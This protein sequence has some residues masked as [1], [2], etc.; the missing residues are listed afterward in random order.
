MRGFGSA[1][2]EKTR[3]A[4][5]VSVVQA[6]FFAR[7]GC[8]VARPRIAVELL[9]PQGPATLTQDAISEIAEACE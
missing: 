6:L 4:L 7:I 2:L 3:S 8:G 1:E 9:P 5:L